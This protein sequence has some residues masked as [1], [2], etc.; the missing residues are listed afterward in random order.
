[1]DSL[2]ALELR[3]R[4]ERTLQLTLPS[5]I[6]FEYPTTE[7]LATYLLQEAL[8]APSSMPDTPLVNGVETLSVNGTAPAVA[9]GAL[10]AATELSGE[11]L[12]AFIAQEFKEAFQ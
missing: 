2:M 5:T 4:L 10:A 8:T 3:R 6:A 11:E 7:R 12:L 9:V 1:M